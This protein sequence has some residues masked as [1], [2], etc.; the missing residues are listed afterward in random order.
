MGTQYRAWIP[1]VVFWTLFL[2]SLALSERYSW[3]ESVWYAVWM[4]I[5][6]VIAVAASLETFLNP[7][8]APEEYVGR[9]GMAI[10]RWIVR[11]FGDDSK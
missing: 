9:M 6:L 2:G 7:G 10:P 5:L 1:A 11:L 8:G 4:L 3:L